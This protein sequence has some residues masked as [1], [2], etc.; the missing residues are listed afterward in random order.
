MKNFKKILANLTF[1][2]VCGLLFCSWGCAPAMDCSNLQA[3]ESCTRVLFIG[4]SYTMVNDL[5]TTFMNLAAKRR[6]QDRSGN[7]GARRLDARGSRQVVRH[8]CEDQ[9]RKMEFY[10]PAG[11]ERGSI[12]STIPHA[13]HVSRSPRPCR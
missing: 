10:Y 1:L 12:H 9:F 3:N 6:T 2:I 5:P 7:V 11:T 13:D 4:N 8:D